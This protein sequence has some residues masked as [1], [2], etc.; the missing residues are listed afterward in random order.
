MGSEDDGFVTVTL[1]KEGESDVDVGVTLITFDGSAKG[2]RM[3]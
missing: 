2:I 3:Q 1:I